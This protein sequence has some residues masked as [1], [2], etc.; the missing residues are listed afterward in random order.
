MDVDVLNAEPLA[1]DDRRFRRSLAVSILASLILALLLPMVHLPE[2]KRFVPEAMP[3]RLAQLVKKV[4]CS[5]NR[6]S[7]FR[8]H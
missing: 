5:R 2:P 4:A 1:E 3:R 7:T 6:Y 8:I